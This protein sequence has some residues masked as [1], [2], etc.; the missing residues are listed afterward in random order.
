MGFERRSMATKYRPRDG[1]TLER[2]AEREA[3]AGN[4]V[5]A[6]E[7]A[8]FNWGT[9]DP[10]TV[11]EYLR[12]ELGCYQRGE[13]NR[14][15]ISAD[16]EARSDL[17]IPTRFKR[18]GMATNRAHTFRVR[19]E[20]AP[21]EQ[22]QGCARISGVTFEFNS[23][24]VRPSV[25]DDLK[26][27]EAALGGHPQA[28]VMIFGHTDKV[29]SDE[30]NKG[31][32]ERRARSVYAFITN[33]P[34]IWEELYKKE[35]WGIRAVQAI[36]KDLGGP[37]DPGPVDGIDGPQTKAAV[38]RYQGDNGLA[39]DG[40]AGPKTRASL[41]AAYMAGKHDIAIDDGRFMDPKHMGCGET[42]P[43]VETEQRCEESRRVTFYLFHEGR[44]PNL[45]C[46]R[47]DLT[48]CNKQKGKPLPRHKEEFHC[49]FYDSIARSC[50]CEG[51]ATKGGARLTK[52]AWDRG[53][54]A[55][56]PRYFPEGKEQGVDL[57]VE[58]MAVKDGVDGSG[59]TLRLYGYYEEAPEGD[60]TRHPVELP[61]SL[62]GIEKEADVVVRAG[63]LTNARVGPR[64]A[65]Q[66]RLPWG[67]VEA[68]DGTKVY[69]VEF[70]TFK[71]RV[72][73]KGGLPEGG[74]ESQELARKVPVVIFANPDAVEGQKRFWES[75]ETIRDLA[76]AKG[77]LALL[78]AGRT[79]GKPSI[80]E[81]GVSRGVIP[82]KLPLTHMRGS[83]Y[84]FYRGHGYL[85]THDGKNPCGCC[86][87]R[88]RWRALSADDQVRYLANVLTP[89]K[90]DEGEGKF[91]PISWNELRRSVKN[92]DHISVQFVID[93]SSGDPGF[94][95]ETTSGNMP[96]IT[97]LRQ[98][99]TAIA[100][101]DR[102]AMREGL[103]FCMSKPN[104]ARVTA[105]AARRLG[106][107]TIPIDP[108]AAGG[109]SFYSA[110][111]ALKGAPDVVRA[112]GPGATVPAGKPIYVNSVE[113]KC[114]KG[115]DV[116]NRRAGFIFWQSTDGETFAEKGGQPAMCFG[117]GGTA[118]W[119]LPDKVD[120]LKRRCPT[121]TEVMY[122]SGCLTAATPAL[123]ESFLKKGT[124]IYIGNRI[125]A[126]GT[127]N[128]Q[129]AEAFAREVFENGKLP[130]EAFDGLK[131]EY[132]GK[133]R[134]AMWKKSGTET[135]YVDR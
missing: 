7:I 82:L 29:G 100:R 72:E 104:V 40:V 101:W 36:L 68:V 108:D 121:P 135:E 91:V 71:V 1:D 55:I 41:F 27:V 15:V 118:E 30:A 116:E 69:P 33:Q 62:L 66:L 85:L 57:F 74:M 103:Q 6:A 123:A 106:G 98:M 35:G 25:V 114:K 99:F 128:R 96:W 9:D 113:A 75:G 86:K 49:S 117:D 45:P 22:F 61:L 34:A 120:A 89:L 16:C 112:T 94:T 24:F 127:W 52:V 14:F 80:F 50:P 105:A 132:V 90:W 11:D 129:M 77:E 53:V 111:A 20:P 56:H 70:A 18:I 87:F 126:W 31:L 88:D 21:P 46:R 47:G 115:E 19:R 12:D 43:M 23:S 3:A 42:N 73:L 95:P 93:E 125:V 28:K 67:E 81:S 134:C 37:Y 63:R 59:F 83:S 133:L 131:A 60:D 79:P 130:E 51:G 119:L 109:P 110:G 102:E 17:L 5:S 39:V 84:T 48:P 78:E 44:L 26:P 122:A 92:R 13:D 4:A 2:I 64:P 76:R 32:S 107:Y 97:R 38:R 10:E 124:R 65:L 58:T 54:P 8:R